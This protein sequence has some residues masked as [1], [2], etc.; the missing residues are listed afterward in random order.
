MSQLPLYEQKS[1]HGSRSKKQI[2]LF[3]I[4]VSRRL[5]VVA[6]R[7]AVQRG[8]AAGSKPQK[9]LPAAAALKQE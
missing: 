6:G 9:K 7:Q 4:T 3:Q 1:S 5:V 8:W 2:A